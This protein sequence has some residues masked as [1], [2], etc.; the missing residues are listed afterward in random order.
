M[1]EIVHPSEAGPRIVGAHWVFVD[2]DAATAE[3][4]AQSCGERL[5][6]AISSRQLQGI[7]AELRADFLRWSDQQMSVHPPV[8]WLRTRLYPNPYL[9]DLFLHCCWLELLT[10][11]ISADGK[12]LVIVTSN[13]GFACAAVQLAHRRKW[14]V[15]WQGRGKF[16]RQRGRRWA[17]GIGGL[18]KHM[19]EHAGRWCLVR[20]ILGTGYRARLSETH[21][22]VSVYVHPQDISATG[23]YR[24]RYF[25]GMVDY[26]ESAGFLPAVLPRYA[27]MTLK[28]FPSFL[29]RLR[30]SPRLFAAPELFMHPFD[31]LVAGVMC[32][33]GTRNDGW[34][35][36]GLDIEKMANS[37]RLT[38][39]M[40]RYSA[41]LL[42]LS[43]LRAARHGLRPVNAVLWH[44][45][46]PEDKAIALAL[47]RTQPQT[48][49]IGIKPFVPM[50]NLMS[51]FNTTGQVEQGVAPRFTWVCGEDQASCFSAH[52]K[53]GQYFVVPALRYA[54]LHATPSS[55]EPEGTELAILLT[56]SAEESLSILRLAA[57]EQSLLHRS[58][59]GIIVKPHPD[60]ADE[61]FKDKV[62]SLLGGEGNYRWVTDGMDV[63]LGHARAVLTAGTSSAVEALGRGIPVMI[64]G[65]AAG[66]E[67]NPLE[68]F[69]PRMW[70][71]IDGESSLRRVVQDWTPAHPL[72]EGDRRRL[73]TH[74]RERFFLRADEQSMRRYISPEFGFNASHHQ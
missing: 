71:V 53:L 29:R 12:P 21:T 45:N 19:V 18:I 64:A 14:V 28:Q 6:P 62:T 13:D 24:D 3:S 40:K 25:R 48:R 17:R 44:E 41:L 23:A 1:F 27:D 43:L 54:H 39:A 51:Q 61:S 52:D 35:F 59:S 16:A 5:V 58:F 68:W 36:R 38:T 72:P 33:A 67:M 50:P 9:E 47:H 34:K 60:L 74:V 10:R 31:L 20:A 73:G 4:L 7:A 63:T 42:H 26:F 8:E 70:C 65:V 2:R 66:L 32:F 69:D 15:Q 49:V 37:T 55:Q 57:L 46:Q 11:W 30:M 56:F 22:L